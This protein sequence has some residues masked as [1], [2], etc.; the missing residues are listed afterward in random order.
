MSTAHLQ[1]FSEHGTERVARLL[2]NEMVG[3][4]KKQKGGHAP[5]GFTSAPQLVI[6]RA[7]GAVYHDD[8]APGSLVDVVDGNLLNH[9]YPPLFVNAGQGRM[10]QHAQGFRD[11]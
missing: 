1:V 5:D 6:P 7:R 3:R 10:L 11:A 2:P 4:R 8:R 9:G